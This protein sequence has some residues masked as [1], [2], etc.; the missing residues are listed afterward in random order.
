MLTFVD[1]QL[2]SNYTIVQGFHPYREG[3]AEGTKGFFH[4]LQAAVERTVQ[5]LR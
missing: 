5:Q 3:E 1:T 4:N 2:Q